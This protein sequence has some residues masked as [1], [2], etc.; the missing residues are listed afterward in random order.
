MRHFYRDLMKYKIYKY[1]FKWQNVA[2][3]VAFFDPLKW[4]NWKSLCSMLTGLGNA[5]GSR[6]NQLS[7]QAFLI[8]KEFHGKHNRLLNEQNQYCTNLLKSI[9]WT[10]FQALHDALK[11]LPNIE[12][13]E[14]NCP[15]SSMKLRCHSI[16]V[17]NAHKIAFGTKR[18]P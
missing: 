5:L 2:C 13:L 3:I 4:D 16:N 6:R 17:S 8:I 1:I 14:A 9:S 12:M 10:S 7:S 11:R 18:W 15:S